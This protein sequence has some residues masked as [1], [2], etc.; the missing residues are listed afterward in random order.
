[1][2]GFRWFSESVDECLDLGGDAA[3]DALRKLIDEANADKDA[4]YGPPE[5]EINI[6]RRRWLALYDEIY[7]KDAA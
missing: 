5:H 1:M 3:L 4:G 7:R 6:A 2:T